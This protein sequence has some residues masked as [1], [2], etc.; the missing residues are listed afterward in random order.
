MQEETSFSRSSSVMCLLWRQ[1]ETEC[2]A[3]IW[4]TWI[5]TQ[6]HNIPKYSP[7]ITSFNNIT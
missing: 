4:A 2:I 1:S 7:G 5:E 3:H 6:V